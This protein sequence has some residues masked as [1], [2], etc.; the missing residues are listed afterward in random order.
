MRPTLKWRVVEEVSKTNPKSELVKWRVA[1]ATPAEFALE[2]AVRRGPTHRPQDRPTE[3]ARDLIWP[4][5]LGPAVHSD[6]TD[7]APDAR[8]IRPALGSSVD[9]IRNGTQS[10]RQVSLKVSPIVAQEPNEPNSSTLE[11]LR[12]G[13][14]LRIARRRSGNLKS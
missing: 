1:M 6:R 8:P 4:Q 14:R 12:A 5:D 7:T 13:V 11:H 9:S 3:I 2:G 10:A